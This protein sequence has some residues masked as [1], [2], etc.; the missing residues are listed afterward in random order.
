[1]PKYFRA[2][3]PLCLF[4]AS[5]LSSTALA[6]LQPKIIGGAES[7]PDNWSFMTALMI[8]KIGIRL[9][10]ASY[11]ASFLFGSN[12]TFFQGKLVDCQQGVE[13]CR[14]ARGKVC[15]IQRGENFF[16]EKVDNC[17]QGGGI[18]A[19]I[20]NNISGP[21]AG[22]TLGSS[23]SADIPAVGIDRD[24]GMELL[25]YLGQNIVFDYLDIVPTN[26]FCGG[27]YLGSRWVVTAAHCVDGVDPRSLLLNVGGHDLRT[28]QTN[29]IGVEK[30]IRHPD[31]NEV[32]IDYDI[33]L[34][35]LSETP[36]NVSPLTVADET[37]LDT[38]IAEGLTA[39]ALGRGVQEPVEP[40]TLPFSETVPSLFEV[41]LPLISNNS[42]NTSIRSYYASLPK[43]IINPVTPRMLCAGLPEGGIGACVGDSGGPLLVANNGE[44][45]LAGITSW[46]IGCAQPGLYDVYTR[47]PFFKSAINAIMA[48]QANGFS[49]SSGAITTVPK[50]A[51][52]QKNNDKTLMERLWSSS[53]S[54]WLLAVGLLLGIS[55]KISLIDYEEKRQ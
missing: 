41:D 19:V 4:L 21:A 36:V 26:S 45:Q 43:A 22:W 46:G 31:Y 34:L 3:L 2:L 44:M 40:N 35:K 42:C 29:I 39:K 23:Y 51:Y 10:G 38:D 32:T 37:S 47:V 55:R 5:L 16:Y 15:L 6:K 52:P 13:V 28:D 11:P 7:A 50:P 14:N 48:G 53:T 8:R 54:L 20:Y 25:N 27:S 18:A 1:M 33:A 49:S 9:D 17:A 12:E 24:A 30:I